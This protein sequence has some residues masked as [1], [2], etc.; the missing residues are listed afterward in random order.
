MP[1]TLLGLLALTILTQLT[2]S[3]QRVT[4][5]AQQN[6][7]RDEFSVAAS[8]MMMEAMELLAARPFDAESTPTRVLAVG[9]PRI[10]K[11]ASEDYD[12]SGL[13]PGS[14]EYDCD[15]FE[16]NLFKCNDLDDYKRDDPDNPDHWWP[17]NVELSNGYT[18]PFEVFVDV[19]YVNGDA[20]DVVV[21]GPTNNKRVTLYARTSL[22]P[23]VGTFIEL[24]RVI[25]Y[26]PNKAAADCVEYVGNFTPAT[27]PANCST[28]R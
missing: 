11:N 23:Q 21:S 2:F 24:Q 15:L 8:G 22:L 26:D 27:P 9:L 5:K 28:P 7:L 1:Q 13:G 20:P 17:A 18:L 14:G 25:A 4:M 12:F 10:P 6:Q 19:D 3:Q 16:V